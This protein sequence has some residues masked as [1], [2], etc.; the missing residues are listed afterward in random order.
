MNQESNQ[1][2]INKLWTTKL[3]V[4]SGSSIL[5]ILLLATFWNALGLHQK[6]T[7]WLAV[8]LMV[9]FG[10]N[11]AGF[12]LGLLERKKNFKKAWVGMIGHLVLILLFVLM[13]GYSIF[14]YGKS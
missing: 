13:V 9:A 12:V 10:M 11:I 5:F 8:G 14:I 3:L 6:S 2:S 1:P 7:I 4:I